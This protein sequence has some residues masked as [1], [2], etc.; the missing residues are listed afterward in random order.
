MMRTSEAPLLKRKPSVYI[1]E[2]FFSS[3]PRERTNLKFLETTLDRNF[4]R[5]QPSTTLPAI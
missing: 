1:R 4:I 2:M 3:Q 5:S